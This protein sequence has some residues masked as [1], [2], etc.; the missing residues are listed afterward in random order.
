M[1]NSATV[2]G[3]LTA[4]PELRTTQSGTP[5][6]AFTVA[7][8]RDYQK[9]GSER[10]TDWIDIVAWRQTA[11]FISKYFRKGSAIIVTG[12]IQ[13]RTYDDRNGN[14]RKAVEIVAERVWFGESKKAE[15]AAAPQFVEV[16]E[17]DGDLPF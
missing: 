12:S 7:C 6:M 13:T 11:E 9:G 8:D 17:A 2:M 5:V 10:Q 16:D 15:T 1:L 3:R 14:K 4:E